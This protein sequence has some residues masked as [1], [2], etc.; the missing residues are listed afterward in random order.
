MILLILLLRNSNYSMK[1]GGMG[2]KR[3]MKGSHFG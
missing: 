1:K 2:M 3:K